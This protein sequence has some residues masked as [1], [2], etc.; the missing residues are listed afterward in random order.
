MDERR[1]LETCRG[2]TCTESKG[3]SCKDQKAEAGCSKPVK[4]KESRGEE[5]LQEGQEEEN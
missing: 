4:Q 3:R 1:H 2:E 5:K